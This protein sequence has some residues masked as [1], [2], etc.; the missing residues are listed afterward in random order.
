MGQL[1]LS[2]TMQAIASA[3]T[4]A[5]VVDRAYAFP[6][7]I[8]QFRQAAVGY[9]R[10]SNDFDHAFGRGMERATI[11]VWV[12]CGYAGEERARDYIS[13]LLS[14]AADVKDALDGTLS[15]AVDSLRVTSWEVETYPF[16]DN[17]QALFIAVRFDC[18]VIT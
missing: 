15:G 16:G 1:D 2:T 12:I 10:G 11:P 8:V 18:D 5:G 6:S 4:T 7:P 9:P 13:G 3:L 17:P 14:G